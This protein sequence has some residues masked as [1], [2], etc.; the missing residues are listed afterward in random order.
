MS[1]T[2][3]T[4]A[5]TAPRAL[6]AEHHVR[7]ERACE[8]LLT[9]TYADDPRALC[10]RWREFADAVEQHM[11]AEEAA[12][13]PLYERAAPVEAN[14]IRLEHARLRALLRRL[15]VEVDLHEVRVGT[16][17]E[18]I[19]S[20]REHARR[21][22]VQ[23]YPWAAHL[24]ARAHRAAAGDRQPAELSRASRRSARRARPRS[25]TTR[26]RRRRRSRSPRARSASAVGR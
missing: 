17:R 20:L 1:A 14:E 7:L 8:D 25:R 24:P 2:A 5:T 13:L 9:D 18:L 4:A 6:L 3:D 10:A 15:D 11:I 21:E 26:R 22:E 23:M 12:I 19:E 16:I